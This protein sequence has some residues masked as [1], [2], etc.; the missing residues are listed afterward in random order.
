MKFS[1][2]LDERVLS[3]GR[4]GGKSSPVQM[5][6]EDSNVIKTPPSK[7]WLAGGRRET[8]FKSEKEK[9]TRGEKNRKAI[10]LSGN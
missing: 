4:K 1:S 5:P 10:D 6:K 3:E 9:R 7:P 8:S 2:W